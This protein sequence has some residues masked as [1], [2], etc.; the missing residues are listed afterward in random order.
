MKLVDGGKYTLNEIEA[1]LL[2]NHKYPAHQVERI[3]PV[4]EEVD[5]L[6][7]E[8][9]AIILAH[10]Y[11]EPPIQLIA[12]VRGDSLKLAYAAREIKDKRLVL[13]S[14][15]LFMAEMVK[16]LS[17]DK[18]VIIPALDAGCSIAEGINGATVKRIRENFP[19]SAIVSYINVYADT[20]A[21][22]DS[23]C[24]SANAQEI[25]KNI[26]GNPVILLPDYFFAKNIFYEL[27][28]N[29]NN[30]RTYLAYKGVDN[31]NI[32]LEDVLNNRATSLSGKGINL[33]SLPKGTCIVH[34]QF[35]PEE[36]AYFRR[37]QKIDVVMAHPEVNPEVA[38]V[39]DFI[40]GTE[41]MIRYAKT[42]PSKKYLVISECD[43]TAP[44]KEACPETEFNTPC[45]FCPYMKRNTLESFLR[46]I[47][48]EVFE[49]NIDK[50]IAGKARMSLERMFELSGK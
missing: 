4:L 32:I 31:G 47:K 37:S 33:P 28:K 46:S 23:V 16:L 49:V 14:T 3:M 42:N 9:N 12:D 48:E 6:R 7:A 17:E 20:K 8:K 22:V 11:Q 34:E 2:D 26:K 19:E 43:L 1:S 15:V 44:L 35:T 27:T 36:I 25:I 38:R 39:S 50:K 30:D 18:K 45:T 24:T 10:Y 5:R 13:S 29:K 41:A 40:G 21:E